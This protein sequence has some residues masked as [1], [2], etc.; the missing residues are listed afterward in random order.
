M[1]SVLKQQ[2]ANLDYIVIDGGSNDD[3]CDVIRS[4]ESSL[5]YWV[6][7]KDSGQY[8]AI[9]K[10][11]SRSTGEIMGWINSDDVMMPWTLSTVASIFTQFPEIQ[12]ITGLPTVIQHGVIHRVSS[13]RPWPQKLLQLGLYTG[14]DVGIVQQEST[15]WRR[16]LW[17]K[18]GGLREDLSLAADFED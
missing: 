7:E 9:N 13:L 8:A 3:S 11:F 17:D 16:S 10:G 4:H 1:A 18:A 12:W 6:S 2:Y 14:G 15:F 5:N